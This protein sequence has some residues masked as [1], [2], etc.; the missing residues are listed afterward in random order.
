M[1]V[2]RLKLRSVLAGVW[3]RVRVDRV[4]AEFFWSVSSIG[5]AVGYYVEDEG[6]G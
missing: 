3:C 5:Y 6:N 1:E 2:E 4:S